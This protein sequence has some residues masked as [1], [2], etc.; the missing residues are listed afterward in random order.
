MG[1]K[2]EIP[3]TDATFNPWIG[4]APVHT[5]CLHCYGKRLAGRFGVEWGPHGTRRLT[6]A[7][8]WKQPLA[9]NRKA[10]REGPP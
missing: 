9:W 3:W 6:S 10:A 5:G 2:T 1:D 8:T 4:C 7:A